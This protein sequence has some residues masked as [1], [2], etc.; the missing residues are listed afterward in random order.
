MSAALT[1]RRRVTAAGAAAAVVGALVA[2]EA[3]REV[4]VAS[5]ADCAKRYVAGGDHVP[6]GHEVSESERYPQQ[7][8]DEHLIPSPG[9]W[10]VY[11]VA[12]NG[13]T[14]ATYIS[15]GQQAKTWNYQPDLITLTV[16]GENTTIVDTITKCFDKVKDHDFSGANSCAAIVQGNSSA[17]NSLN[18]NLVT[19]LDYYRRQMAGRPWLVVAVTGYANPYMSA[20]S[21]TT[22]VPQLCQPLVDTAQ[23]CSTRWNQLPSALNTLDTVI[24]KLNTTIENAVKPFVTG[25]Q[26]RFVFVNPYEKFKDHCMKMQVNIITVVNHGNYSD[27]HTSNKDFG[28]TQPWWVEGSMGSKSPDYLDPASNGALVSK[29]QT[30]TGMGVHPNDKGHD[31][32]ADLVWEAVKQKMGVPEEPSTDVCSG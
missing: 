7:L 12:A 3:A 22:N 1:L 5:A 30:T 18:S 8:L 9:A 11:N 29:Q 32:I 4:E 23:T 16:G 17:W 31:C 10:C 25:T 14:S 28:C 2:Y 27:T 19:T 26:G 24:K 21:A 6:A 15:G 13:T 20:S